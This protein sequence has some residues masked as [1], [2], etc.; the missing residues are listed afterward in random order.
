MLN[1]RGQGK[2]INVVLFFP[3][4]D[5]IKSFLCE[6]RRINTKSIPILP[7]KNK[8]MLSQ[9]VL[10]DAQIHHSFALVHMEL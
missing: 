3:K 8:W 7:L 4:V 9:N 5:L 2:L 6:K 1:L 10:L